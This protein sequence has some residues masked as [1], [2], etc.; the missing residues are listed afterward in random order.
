MPTSCIQPLIC[1]SP[2]WPELWSLNDV[3]LVSS[4]Y[5][6]DEARRNLAIDRPEAVPRLN[7]LLR[8]VST[9]DTPQ[10][11][12]LAKNIRLDP[13]DRPILLA[14]IHGKAGHLLTGDGRHF[15]HL[16]EKRIEGVLVLRPAQY[17]ETPAP[18]LKYRLRPTLSGWFCN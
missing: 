12:K 3:Q 17:F 4:A 7:R 2:D 9:V 6:I 8:P 13:N 1:N 18:P 5:A 10:G 15:G 16:Y 11:V 14:A